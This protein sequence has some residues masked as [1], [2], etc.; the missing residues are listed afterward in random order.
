MT[1]IDSNV[2]T[3]AS[4]HAY[5]APRLTVIGSATDVILGFAGDGDDYLGYSFP[6]FEFLEDSPD[7]HAQ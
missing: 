5:A 3:P 7:E 4:A 1:N 6:E 2:P